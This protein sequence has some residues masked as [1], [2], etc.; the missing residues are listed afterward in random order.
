MIISCAVTRIIKVGVP[1]LRSALQGATAANVVYYWYEKGHG[2][3]WTPHSTERGKWS[4]VRS[5]TLPGRFAPRKRTPVPTNWEAQ[6]KRTFLV[7][8]RME[9]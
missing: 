2:A 4:V 5:T 6:R 1:K 9:P 8:A 3:L 7:P